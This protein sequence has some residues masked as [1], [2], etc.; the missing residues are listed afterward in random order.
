MLAL[1]ASAAALLLLFIAGIVWA[2][3]GERPGDGLPY[4]ARSYELPGRATGKTQR[5]EEFAGIETLTR[6]AEEGDRESQ[7]ELAMRLFEKSA[8]TRDLTTRDSSLRWLREAAS[9]GYAPAQTVLGDRYI[10]GRG[11]IQDFARAADWYL[12]AAE[13]GEA[14]AM[15]SLGRM[16]RSGRGVRESAVEAYVWLNV[17]AARGEERADEIRNQV[18]SALSAEQLSDAQARARELD[19]EIPQLVVD[20][21][22]R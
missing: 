18:M 2:V 7:Y 16:A 13:Q 4:A 3:F 22:V 14:S 11:V 19:E 5:A 21:G 15:Y 1:W 20:Q 10:N 6:A 9:G 8:A 17:A 12:K